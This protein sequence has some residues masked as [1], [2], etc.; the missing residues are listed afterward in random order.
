MPAFLFVWFPP[1]LPAV[2]NRH[3]V[4][5]YLVVRLQLMLF[6]AVA[7]GNFY[8]GEFWSGGGDREAGDLGLYLKKP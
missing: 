5:G 6:F 1:F 4:L 2:E 8:C 3:D 7:E